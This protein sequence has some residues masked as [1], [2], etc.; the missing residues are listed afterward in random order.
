MYSPSALPAKLVTQ[1]R[2]IKR[3]RDIKFSQA[4]LAPS[5]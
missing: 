1:G 4:E 2:D 3:I 5:T